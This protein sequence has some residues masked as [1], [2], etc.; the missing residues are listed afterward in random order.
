MQE[1]RLS[2]TSGTNKRCNIC[3]MKMPEEREQGRERI[4][5]AIMTGNFTKLT[6]DSKSHIQEAQGT[7]SRINSKEPCS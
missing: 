7:P 4:F 6:Q 3:I 5:K 1:N 2:K